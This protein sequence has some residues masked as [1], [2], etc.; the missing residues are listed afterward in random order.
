MHGKN[1]AHKD[2]YKIGCWW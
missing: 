1:M 2:I